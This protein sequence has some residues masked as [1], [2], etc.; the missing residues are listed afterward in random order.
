[1]TNAIT[2]QRRGEE[3]ALAEIGTACMIRK[4]AIQAGLRGVS[5]EC[6]NAIAIHYTR[7]CA[8]KQYE[9]LGQ[10]SNSHICIEQVS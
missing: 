4:K 2:Q 3:C 5:R 6:L 8:S 7:H 10:R 1:M 9:W